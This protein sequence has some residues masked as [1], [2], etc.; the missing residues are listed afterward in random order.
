VLKALVEIVHKIL[1]MRLLNGLVNAG[2]GRLC[3][4]Q[5]VNSFFGNQACEGRVPPYREVLTRIA[6]GQTPMCS[7]PL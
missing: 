2:G 1:K 7:P 6:F 4:S 5:F 3:V